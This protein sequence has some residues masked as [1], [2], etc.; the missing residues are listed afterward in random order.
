MILSKKKKIVT[1]GDHFRNRKERV[2]GRFATSSFSTFSTDDSTGSGDFSVE[3]RGCS[4]ALPTLE[5]L[6]GPVRLSGWREKG[7]ALL[8]VGEALG[9]KALGKSA[10]CFRVESLVSDR[11]SPLQVHCEFCIAAISEEKKPLPT[12]TFRRVTLDA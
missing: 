4:V 12:R 6:L 5:D 8:V 1:V 9:K 10:R 3:R 11:L 2:Q 7:A